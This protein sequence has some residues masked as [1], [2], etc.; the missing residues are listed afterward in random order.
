MV[1]PSILCCVIL[2][3]NTIA[4]TSVETSAIFQIEIFI[5]LFTILETI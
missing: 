2:E 5:N 3:R 4:I 1:R